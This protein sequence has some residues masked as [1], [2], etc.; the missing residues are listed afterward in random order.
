[1]PCIPNVLTAA[2]PAAAA[3]GGRTGPRKAGLAGGLSAWLLASLLAPVLATAGPPQLVLV[4]D[5]PRPAE[6]TAIA[7]GWR[8]SFLD[9]GHPAVR[10][11]ADIVR[12][13][14]R[15]EA[16]QGPQVILSGGSLLVVDRVEVRDGR[17]WIESPTWGQVDMPLEAVRG[18]VLHPPHDATVR[19][20]L[21]DRV[22]RA[23]GEHDQ[24]WLENEDTAGG[25]LT[26]INGRQV[27]LRTDTDDVAV[28]ISDVLAVVRRPE[29]PTATPRPAGLEVL[30]GLRDGSLLHCQGAVLAEGRL[31]V[32]LV[33]G[34]ELASVDP[35]LP[36]D[37]PAVV[38]LEVLGGRVTY[39][40]DIQPI[41]YRHI[42]YLDLA[43]PWHADRNVLGGQLRDQGGLYSK[44]LGMHSAARLAYSL[45]GNPRRFDAAVALDQ[46][47]GQGGSVVFRVFLDAGPE[48]WR[49]AWE[50]PVVRG[51]QPPLPLS[52]ELGG[53]RRLALLVDFAD[54]ADVLDYANWL[55]P[56]LVGP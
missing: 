11:A 30:I 52:V 45:E 32:Q 53:A 43:W 41:S 8:L 55:D 10:S 28:A 49:K 3:V 5:S 26:A 20:R 36:D 54:R 15:V 31:R 56:R 23:T 14:Q 16:V 51:G 37:A 35:L 18:I 27:L 50:S 47:A 2:V 6:L 1:M 34:P 38:S 44:G 4:D 29:R 17:L 12:W 22:R 40:P 9:A 25:Q 42:P 19:D 21:I 24:L 33:D 7:E 13:G 46:A 39:L 48:G